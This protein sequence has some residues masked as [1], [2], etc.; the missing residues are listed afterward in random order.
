MWPGPVL[1]TTGDPRQVEPTPVA[2]PPGAEARPRP[3]QAGR[4][5]R[6]TGRP[7]G[8]GGVQRTVAAL[9]PDL[10][11]DRLDVGEQL[12]LLR[13]R[14]EDVV[15][16]ADALLELVEGVE[17]PV[18]YLAPG[19]EVLA[20]PFHEPRELEREQDLRRLTVAHLRDGVERK[21]GECLRIEDARS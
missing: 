13:D 14:A 16:R 9:G 7:A 20:R 2:E 11:L 19:P 15:H 3:A 4:A 8:H 1:R 6:R 5:G 17:R 18:G 10:C 21:D 12:F